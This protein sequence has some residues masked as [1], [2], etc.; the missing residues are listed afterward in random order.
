MRYNDDPVAHADADIIVDETAC[1]SDACY[2]EVQT[3]G[4]NSYASISLEFAEGASN[5]AVEVRANNN[6]CV[7]T[8]TGLQ[9]KTDVCSDDKVN[10]YFNGDRL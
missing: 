3:T 10:V 2:V 4:S 9:Y 5:R 6:S 8:P 7:I 1:S